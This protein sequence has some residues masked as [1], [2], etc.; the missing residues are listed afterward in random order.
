MRIVIESFLHEECNDEISWSVSWSIRWSSYFPFSKRIIHVMIASS[1]L[2]ISSFYLSTATPTHLST[3]LYSHLRLVCLLSIIFLSSHCCL[4]TTAA[5]H[6]LR[7]RLEADEIVIKTSTRLNWLFIL[8]IFDAML[9]F[10]EEV[11]SS[12]MYRFWFEIKDEL[13]MK[14]EKIFLYK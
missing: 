2:I 14:Y 13:F 3:T 10:L 7:N 9:I 4:S 1:H 8:L 6:W 12:L 5:S 11:S